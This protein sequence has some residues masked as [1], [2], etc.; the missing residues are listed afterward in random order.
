MTI[1]TYL[2]EINKEGDIGAQCGRQRTLAGDQVET[3]GCLDGTLLPP[4]C[5]LHADSSCTVVRHHFPIAA[6]GKAPETAVYYLMQ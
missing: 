1:R 4:G 2:L 6:S 3:F 5:V